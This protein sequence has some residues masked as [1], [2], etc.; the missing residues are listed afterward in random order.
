MRDVSKIIRL[1]AGV[2][3]DSTGSPRSLSVSQYGSAQV[4]QIN[5]KLKVVPFIVTTIN[6]DRDGD[7][8]IPRGIETK[9]YATNPVV[10]FGHQEWV[11]PI[12]TARNPRT[13][14]LAWKTS[15][16]DARSVV[17]FD[18][19]DPDAM[20]IYG[21][22][23]RGMLS[24]TSI[25][26]V[27]IEAYKRDEYEKAHRGS[28]RDSM[29]PMGWM[30]KRVDLTEFS[31][32]GVPSNAGAIRDA[33]DTEKSFI[34]PQLQKALTPYAAQPRGRCFSGWCP[35]P[36]KAIRRDT[37]VSKSPRK[38]LHVVSKDLCPNNG[39][40]T[41]SDDYGCPEAF[42]SARR[43][44]VDCKGCGKSLDIVPFRLKGN[45]VKSTTITRSITKGDHLSGAA[46]DAGKKAALND[47]VNQS[48]TSNP[49][50]GGINES[51]WQRAY[52][53]AKQKFL[54]SG[55]WPGQKVGWTLGSRSYTGV[56]IP[57][58]TEQGYT[59]V[60]IERI[61]GRGSEERQSEV[62]RTSSIQT[63]GLTKKSLTRSVRKSV[64]KGVGDWS[65]TIEGKPSGLVVAGDDVRAWVGPNKFRGKINWK[66]LK[67]DWEYPLPDSPDRYLLEREAFL[68]AK[69]KAKGKSAAKS[70]PHE[71]GCHTSPGK[72]LNSTSGTSGGYLVPPNQEDEDM[73]TK[74]PAVAKKTLLDDYLKIKEGFLRDGDASKAIKLLVDFK[75]AGQE[76]ARKTVEDW[77]KDRARQSSKSAKKTPA[78]KTVQK[79]GLRLWKWDAQRGKWMAVTASPFLGDDSIAVGHRDSMQR[80]FPNETFALSY[81]QPYAPPKKSTR[82]TAV[83]K[84]INQELIQMQNSHPRTWGD[85]AI[86]KINSIV[87]GMSG[88][89]CA[90]TYAALGNRDAKNQEE[91]RKK[92]RSMFLTR[93]GMTQRVEVSYVNG[94]RKDAETAEEEA[95][96]HDVDVDVAE[97]A[98]E[99]YPEV[100]EGEE[101]PEEE[102][103]EDIAI[104]A[105]K[106]PHSAHAL[107]KMNEHLRAAKDWLEGEDPMFEPDSGVKAY[108]KEELG[109]VIDD[110][111]T[112]MGE[113]FG[114]RYPDQDMAKLC[115]SPKAEVDEED[116]VT[117]G[118][119]RK[120][121]HKYAETIHVPSNKVSEIKFRIEDK[122]GK[123]R[124]GGNSGG[125]VQMDIEGDDR[126]IGW[127]IHEDRGPGGEGTLKDFVDGETGYE[128]MEDEDG[129]EKGDDPND[130]N[131]EEEEFSNDLNGTDDAE[132][133]T[134]EDANEIV[135]ESTEEILERYAASGKG[136]KLRGYDD[137]KRGGRKKDANILPDET[138]EH[139]MSPD[140]L[141]TYLHKDEMEEDVVEM[142]DD[143]PVE[144]SD[145]EEELVE[146]GM[147]KGRKSVRRKASYDFEV[148]PD[149]LEEL[150]TY[151][152]QNGMKV[153]V[154]R[155][156]GSAVLVVIDG[157]SQEQVFQTRV[158]FGKSPRR[159]STD[160][161][162]KILDRMESKLFGRN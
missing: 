79:E 37:V 46:R 24:A 65:G 107:A 138:V 128:E 106:A 33:L 53:T 120:S 64:R 152:T 48:N 83:R 12:G 15:D 160:T 96:E 123:V 39:R 17:Y 1:Y 135:N 137:F 87:G 86:A 140:E 119:R 26:F 40:I 61:E 98:I 51:E 125:Y 21:K 32:V 80:Q 84:G 142:E 131:L 108:F 30:F 54:S 69:S 85:D 111:L 94:V 81:D 42:D 127:A 44:R 91:A 68:A 16:V 121:V 104:E 124:M 55:F 28:D 116:V 66:L 82:K 132:S 47:L 49:Y 45:P 156:L 3:K 20:F 75:V 41:L 154:I 76:G 63:S 97:E 2:V 73:K 117:K 161:F 143:D 59:K 6:E 99:E 110:H 67:I 129:I 29:M 34:T 95:L 11:V 25:A 141:E 92:L 147:E 103:V 89:D 77:A 31:I 114:E 148:S 90:D 50:A 113:M 122:G 10:F 155:Q 146:E 151:A 13:K 14:Q 134:E 149:K 9:N 56:V 136:R 18:A 145:G 133:M 93:Y 4:D 150:R 159:K 126:Q 112:K 62:G 71:C 102:A 109:P 72:S 162:D 36:A 58:G 35:V 23:Q 27:P 157:P 158:R 70:T 19:P 115:G 139:Q 52:D 78:R 8:V 43:G 88:K 105:V 7:V 130:A 38:S 57:P 118:R 100:F 101:T 5:D 60:R 74:K 153:D 22:V 144:K